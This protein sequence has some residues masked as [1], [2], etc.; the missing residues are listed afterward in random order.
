MAA[1]W[2]GRRMAVKDCSVEMQI[3]TELSQSKQYIAAPHVHINGAQS[4]HETESGN[5]FKNASYRMDKFS[6]SLVVA[7]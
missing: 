5:L 1:A 4:H 2:H 6:S 7:S 3:V